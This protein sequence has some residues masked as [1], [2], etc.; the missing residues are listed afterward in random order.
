MS[1]NSLSDT[2]KKQI[3]IDSHL[4]RFKP[5]VNCIIIFRSS[6]DPTHVWV[7]FTSQETV[8]KSNFFHDY[9]LDEKHWKYSVF[10]FIFLF[11]LRII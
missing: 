5:I 10:I 1:F 9:W 3:L 7:T 8:I 4:K 2:W 6:L 11:L